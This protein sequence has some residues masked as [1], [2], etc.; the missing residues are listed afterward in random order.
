[1]CFDTTSSNT[2]RLNG[3]CVLQ[4]QALGCD[5]LHLPCRHHMMGLKAGA[6]FGVAWTVPQAQRSSSSK[7][8]KHSGILLILVSDYRDAHSDAYTEANIR[9][10]S[11]DLKYFIN[12]YVQESQPRDDY[13]EFLDVSRQYPRAW[14]KFHGTLS[15]ALDQVD[16]KSYLH[17]MDVSTSVSTDRT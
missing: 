13:R 7:G 10:V 6:A 3:A 11:K 15:N 16:V 8:S 17:S 5:V 12:H 1:M 4:E 9:E 14:H 2:G